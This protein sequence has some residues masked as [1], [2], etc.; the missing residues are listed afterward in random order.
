M[1]KM[2]IIVRGDLPLCHQ[3]VQSAHALQEF[4]MI[5]PEET[6]SWFSE[7]NTLALLACENEAALGVI[8]T[9]AMDYG[10][11]VAC[12]REP[13][14][15]NELTAIALGSRGKRLIRNLPLALQTVSSL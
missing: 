14:R 15:N 7:S 1:M 2:Y 9:K 3:A 10:I 12:F 11:S 4:N 8:V 5:H 13:D 6:R